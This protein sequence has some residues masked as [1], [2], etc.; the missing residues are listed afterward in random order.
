M[1]GRVKPHRIPTLTFSLIIITIMVLPLTSS[2]VSHAYSS[3]DVLS[4]IDPNLLAQATAQGKVEAIVFLRDM[5]LATKLSLSKQGYKA[6]VEGLKTHAAT[7]QSQFLSQV[8]RL[9]VKVLR[10]FWLVNAILVEA[11]KQQLL[12]MARSPLVEKIIPNFEVHVIEP[13]NREPAIFSI[14]ATTVSS[15]GVYKIRAPDLWSQGITGQGV[16]VAV[17][18]TGVDISH[19]ALQGKMFTINPSDSRYPGGWIEFDSNGNPVCSEPHDTQ[20]HG[21][22]VSGTVLG[23]DGQSI[24][25][26]VAPGAKLMHALVLP[27]GQGSFA[28]VLAG[29]EWAIDPYTCTGQRTGYPAHVIS[30]SLGANGYYGDYLLDAVRNALL[31]NIVVVA[32][33]GNDGAGTSSNPGN[34]WGVIGV[35]AVDQND[36]VAYFSSG[37]VVNWDNP[38]SNWPFFGYYPT[39]YIKPDVSAPGVQI[40]SAVPGG[41]YESWDGTSMATPHVA[42]VVALI[43]DALDATS[44]QSPTSQ[45]SIPELVYKALT[46]TAIDLGEQGQDTRYGWGRVD[47]YAAVQRAIELAQGGSGGGGGEPQP[48][49]ATIYGYVYDAATGDALAGAKVTIVETGDSVYTNTDGYFSF[50]VSPGTYTVKVE[51][52]GYYSQSKQVTVSSGETKSVYFQLQPIRRGSTIAVV[53]NK[54]AG[55][56]IPALLSNAGFSVVEYDSIDQLLSELSNGNP[57]GVQV[58]V[59]DHWY[60]DGSKPSSDTVLAFLRKANELGL[61]VVFLGAPYSSYTG[62]LALYIYDSTI[63]AAGFPAPDSRKYAWPRDYYVT[64]YVTDTSSPLFSGVSYDAGD[65]EFYVADTSKSTYTDYEYVYFEDDSGVKVHGYIVDYYYYRYGPF[66]ATWKTPSG[67]TWVYLSTGAESRWMQYLEPGDDGMYSSSMARVLV[68]A[69]ILAGGQPSTSYYSVP[70]IASLEKPSPFILLPQAH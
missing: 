63:E 47:A 27:N 36:N 19:P 31:A 29:M 9:H 40:T 13:V 35:G 16:R 64:V 67:A 51:K 58:V 1:C 10:K 39:S 21:T 38:P 30:M 14:Y 4:K 43:L 46:E 54:Y 5:P 33:I 56:H 66:A 28:A 7:V 20:G 3:Q 25:I 65:K 42:G 57:R 17:L 52:S 34:I 2:I 32:A 12:L 8:S 53:G 24:V 70:F 41:G 26:G 48:Q 49:P 6:F 59:I 37:E 15:W 62:M 22:H 23:G 44:F 55:H 61:G 69:V 11:T 18:D 50:T 60:S 45:Y 68:N